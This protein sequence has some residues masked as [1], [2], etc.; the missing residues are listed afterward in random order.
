[1]IIRKIMLLVGAVLMVFSFMGKGHSQNLEIKQS[2]FKELAGEKELLILAQNRDQFARDRKRQ[3]LMVEKENTERQIE[4]VENHIKE[5]EERLIN[6]LE[7]AQLDYDQWVRR[8]G[9]SA[10][11]E[12]KLNDM[13]DRK[14]R[15]TLEINQQKRRLANLNEELQNIQNKLDGL[16]TP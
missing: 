3:S 15:E 14:E 8:N 1:M 4:I 12:S 7:Q 10:V 9:I 16:R 5:R 6:F 2:P 13:N 11:S